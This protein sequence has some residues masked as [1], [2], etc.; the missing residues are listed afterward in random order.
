MPTEFVL[1]NVD[2]KDLFDNKSKEEKE[3]LL[4]EMVREAL[5]YGYKPVARKYC[6]Y[7]A[8]VRRWVRIYQEYGEKGLKL[9]KRRKSSYEQLSFFE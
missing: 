7:P 5:I 4:P 9:N 8:T 3:M 1:Y 2:K 6:T